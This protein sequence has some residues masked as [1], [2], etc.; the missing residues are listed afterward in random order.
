MIL[1]WCGGNSG[2]GEVKACTRSLTAN[3]QMSLFFNI[4]EKK[5]KRIWGVCCS[6]CSVPYLP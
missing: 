6:Y 5:E 3:N 2:H 4:E 1:P